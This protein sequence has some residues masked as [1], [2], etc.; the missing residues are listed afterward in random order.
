MSGILV[1]DDHPIIAKACSLVLEG[2]GVGSVVSAATIDAG[3]QAFLAHLPDV[4]II[5]LCL[6]GNELDG[7]T[8]IRRIRLHDTGAKILV[9]TMRSDRSSFMSAIEAGAI[10]Y[11]MKDSPTEEFANAVEQT[12]QGRRYIDPQ[13]ALNLVFPKNA[14]LDERE[15]Q[16]LDSLIGDTL[17]SKSLPEAGPH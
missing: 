7:I 14:A 4:S 16:I 6:G 13:L 17:L 15:Q 9:F 2:V 8:L 10:G 5:D 12:R 1:V 11:V 3:Y